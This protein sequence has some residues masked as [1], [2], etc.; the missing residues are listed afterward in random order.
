[1]T[2]DFWETEFGLAALPVRETDVWRAAHQMIKMFADDDPVLLA[3]QR[4]DSALEQGDA[5]NFALWSRVTEAVK[6]LLVTQ[7]DKPTDIN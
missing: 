1:V 4:A 3:T 6:Q 5:R 7:P 2:D